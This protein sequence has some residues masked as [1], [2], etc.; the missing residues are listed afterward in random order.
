MGR[1]TKSE[2][3][4]NKIKRSQM[5]IFIGSNECHKIKFFAN[6]LDFNV[7]IIII[8]SIRDNVIKRKTK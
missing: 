7:P 2:E 6:V 8:E 5:P 1:K 3:K 4:Q